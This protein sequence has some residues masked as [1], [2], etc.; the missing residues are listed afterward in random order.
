MGEEKTKQWTGVLLPH[1]DWLRKHQRPLRDAETERKH[2]RDRSN[3]PSEYDA[4]NVQS[5]TT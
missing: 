5:E 2:E 1:V 3:P 4:Q